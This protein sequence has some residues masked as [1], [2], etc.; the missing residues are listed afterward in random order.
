MGPSAVG[1][2]VVVLLLAVVGAA[3]GGGGDAT[4][5]GEVALGGGGG[6]A[7]DG[8]VALESTRGRSGVLGI[9]QGDVGGGD[10]ETNFMPTTRG[11]GRISNNFD[12][13]LK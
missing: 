2:L 13:T 3:H 9:W 12:A 6:G 8:N 1:L 5:S 7:V 4:L 10:E 11:I